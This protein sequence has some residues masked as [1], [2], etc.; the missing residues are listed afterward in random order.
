MGHGVR[1]RRLARAALRPRRRAARRG[2]GVHRG[3]PRRAGGIRARRRSRGGARADRRTCPP[4]RRAGR[5][6]IGCRR[7]CRRCSDVKRDVFAALDRHAPPDAVLASSTSAI[8]ASQFTEALAGPRALSRRASGESAASRAGRRAVRR[9]VDLAGGHRARAARLHRGRAGADRRAP[10]D[11][12]L[13][14]QPAAGRA[15]VRGDA[16]RRRRL[17]V[18][19][20]SRQDGARRPRPALVVHGTARDD[21]AQRARRRRRLLRALR[22]LLPA[23]RRG[24]AGAVRLGCGERRAG[25]RGARPAAGRATRST[26]AR[27]GATAG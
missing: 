21:R 9:A 5:R 11:R 22:R 17:R 8:P 1:P 27:A 2:A 25:R 15:A 26:R 24:A 10:R 7:T 16:S 14:P 13:H 3:E 23:A 19:R 12:R 6:A 18:A 20:G 4:R